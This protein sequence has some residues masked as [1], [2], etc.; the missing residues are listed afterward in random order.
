MIKSASGGG[1]VACDELRAVLFLLREGGIG[2]KAAAAAG[3]VRAHCANDD[4]LFAFD[5]ALSVDRRVAAAHTDGQQL[6]DFFGDGEETR[7]RLERAAAVIGVQA[8]DDDAFAEIGE[9]G[10]NIHDFIAEELRFV[11]ADDFGTRRKLFHDLGS[12][13]YRIRG[14]AKAGMRDD[15]VGGV[16]FVAGGLEDLHTLA[17]DLRAAQAANQLFTLAGKHRADHD[18]DPAHIAFDDVHDR[19]LLQ[20]SARHLQHEGTRR[21]GCPYTGEPAAAAFRYIFLL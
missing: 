3:F 12:F 4:Q 7:H 5:E 11:D 19:L 14:N 10:A 16:A 18:F 13:K 21:G 17:R 6:G 2:F 8:G 15:F 20:F 9:L 1:A